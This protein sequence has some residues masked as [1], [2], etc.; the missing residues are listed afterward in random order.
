M[1]KA[2]YVISKKMICISI[3]VILLALV[4][5][6]DIV[7]RKMLSQQSKVHQKSSGANNDRQKVKK[8]K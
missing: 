4:N 7:A 1:S 2:I 3:Y 8:Y 5:A 6:I